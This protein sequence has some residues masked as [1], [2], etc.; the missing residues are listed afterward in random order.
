MIE[1]NDFKLYDD[2]EHGK[3]LEIWG[4]STKHPDLVFFFDR[5]EK[6]EWVDEEKQVF[7]W[8]LECASSLTFPFTALM[9]T[10]FALKHTV[11]F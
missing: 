4:A 8:L 3:I 10:Q 11:N 7:Q 1:E 2:E 6:S 5:F 9:L